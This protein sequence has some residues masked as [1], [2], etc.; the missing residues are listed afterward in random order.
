MK[1]LIEAS[2]LK[3]LLR[4][5]KSDAAGLRTKLRAFALDPYGEHSWAKG[6]GGGRGRIRHGDWRA[7]Y[8]IN[9]EALLI[10]VLKIGN[11]KDIYR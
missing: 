7:I 1:L 2:A 3:V 9:G 8:E 5:P 6:F 10:T 4:M 11:R